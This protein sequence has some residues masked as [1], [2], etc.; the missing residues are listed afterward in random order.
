M[1]TFAPEPNNHALT[2]TG[3]M[4]GHALRFGGEEVA[5]Y[6]TFEGAANGLRIGREALA[7]LAACLA[8]SNLRSAS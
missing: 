1:T 6:P 5:V 3:H 2:L 4:D 8:C 7:M